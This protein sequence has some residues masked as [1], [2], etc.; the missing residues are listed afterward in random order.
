MSDSSSDDKRSGQAPEPAGE[1]AARPS[2][3]PPPA[4][5]SE[6]DAEAILPSA[7]AAEQVARRRFFRQFA[8]EVVHSAATV[9][10]MAGALQRQ[11]MEAAT[12]ILGTSGVDSLG[13][14]IVPEVANPAAGAAAGFRTSFRWGDDAIYLIDQRRLP[15]ELV[16][17]RCATAGEVAWAIREMVVR[18]APAMAQ[19]AAIGLALTAQGMAGSTPFV[20][21]AAIRGSGTA[22]INARPTAVNV[23]WA[24]ERCLEAMDAVG[25]VDADGQVIADAI[26]REAEAIV[27]EAAE[28][29]ERLATL[30][31]AELPTPEDRPLQLLTH[32]NAGPLACG[33]FGTALGIVQVA[34]HQGRQVHVFVDETR[35]FLQGARLTAW[36]LAQAGVGHTLIVDAAAGWVFTRYA[37][38]A[39]LVGAD[40]IAANGDTANKIGTYPLAVLARRHGIPFYV[41]APL[42]SVDPT[43]PDGAAIP[44]EERSGE[45]VTSVRGTLIA[46]P[47]TSALNPG[48]DVTPHDL[49][50][51]IVTEAGVFRPPYATQ[52]VDAVAV[53]VAAR[54]AR[55]ATVAA[56]AVDVPA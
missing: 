37:V 35:P 12:S 22:L 42:A 19:A 1:P 36:E 9:V 27:R 32:C 45:E 41:C 26:R 46:P 40:R 49:I 29:H 53:A 11:S 15:S 6:L 55:A 2:A 16:E 8:G 51:A 14:G 10:G 20:R 50:S 52:L 38:D 3:E 25:D 34:V 47:T 39:V 31:L 28:D 17:M 13:L 7:P 48:F 54:K 5:P 30:G 18:G 44:I 33:Q 56:A 43:T 24:V 21:R 4:T 23:R